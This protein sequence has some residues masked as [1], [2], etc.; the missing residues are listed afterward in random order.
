MLQTVKFESV[1]KV[2]WNQAGERIRG[3]HFQLVE[4]DLGEKVQTGFFVRNW[5]YD[6]HTNWVVAAQAVYNRQKPDRIFVVCQYGE[7]EGAKATFVTTAMNLIPFK[8]LS[9]GIAGEN[10]WQ[11]FPDG[12]K[13]RKFSLRSSANFEIGAEKWITFRLRA[14]GDHKPN[15]NAVFKYMFIENFVLYIVY[16][17]QDAKETVNQLFTKIALTY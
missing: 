11:T 16:G 7:F 17:D 2:T 8:F 3:D 6:V 14:G 10:L 1:Q 4:F 9:I 5:S 15:F 13:T 12:Q